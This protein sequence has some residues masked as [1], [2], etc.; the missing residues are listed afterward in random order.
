MHFSRVL[1]LCMIPAFVS[2]SS[3]YLGTWKPYAPSLV[4]N[5]D[6]ATHLP[7]F[8]INESELLMSTT[9]VTIGCRLKI[10]DNQF[11]CCDFAVKSISTP[12]IHR[13]SIKHMKTY[14]NVSKNGLRFRITDK[15]TD[16][17]LV[18]WEIKE[19]KGSQLFIKSHTQ[20]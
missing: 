1:K 7:E 9:T 19:E 4:I 3:K 15:D 14:M 18:E 10:D 2:S 16:T 11:D 20:S 12:H 6:K 5:K 17:I 8:T 13:V